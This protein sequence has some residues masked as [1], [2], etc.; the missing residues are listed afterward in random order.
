MSDVTSFHDQVKRGD[1]EA[2]RAALAEDPKLLDATNEAGQSAFLLAKYYG[3]GL[4]ADYLL[5][6]DPKLDVFNACVAGLAPV[7][8]SAV[9]ENKKLLE[10]YSSDGWTVLHLAAFFGHSELAA[11]L[12]ERGADGEQPVNELNEEHTAACGGRGAEDSGGAGVIGARCGCKCSAG[13]RM[14]RSAWRCTVWR[15]RNR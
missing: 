10:A 8:L 6:L 12:L 9:D 3:Q 5:S 7:V 11:Q 14:D 4:T 13:R 15:S 2:V 1:L